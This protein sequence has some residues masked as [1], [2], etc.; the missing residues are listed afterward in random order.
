MSVDRRAIEGRRTLKFMCA[1]CL[2]ADLA[3]VQSAHDAGT[4]RTLGN[5]S[6]GQIL[7]HCTMLF[8]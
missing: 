3:A 1:G 7:Q 2:K 6:A 5:W 8:D 4:L